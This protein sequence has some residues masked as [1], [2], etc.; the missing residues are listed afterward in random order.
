MPSELVKKMQAVRNRDL[1]NGVTSIQNG[2]LTSND[3]AVV[4]AKASIVSAQEI[5]KTARTGF[6]SVDRVAGTS[7]WAEMSTFG[8]LAFLTITVAGGLI[9]LK[10]IFDSK[11]QTVQVS[12]V[13]PNNSQDTNLGTVKA[14]PAGTGSK[15]DWGQL[16][17]N[18]ASVI[19][20]TVNEMQ[21]KQI[22][23]DTKV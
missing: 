7:W 17:H 18:M 12:A 10:F 13:S 8:K 5:G 15:I 2:H 4:Q 1:L 21:E 6:H 23:K 20:N 11:N 19:V 3:V 22:E 14:L 16:K 9:L